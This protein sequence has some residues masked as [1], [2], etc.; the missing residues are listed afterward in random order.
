[1]SV[2]SCAIISLDFFLSF[3]NCIA[4][5]KTNGLLGE[6]GRNLFKWERLTE[7]KTWRG[8]LSV[9]RTEK[10]AWSSVNI[11]GPRNDFWTGLKEKYEKIDIFLYHRFDATRLTIKDRSFLFFLQSSFVFLYLNF[12][13]GTLAMVIF[14]LLHY[15]N[16]C[17]VFSHAQADHGS[18]EL[19][20]LYS[21]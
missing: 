14:Y 11:W 3:E 2:I 19:P 4:L 9:L 10:A 18:P 20:F 1:M 16:L 12:F 7:P 17:H 15:A 5:Q 21:P 8:R 6:A 13:D